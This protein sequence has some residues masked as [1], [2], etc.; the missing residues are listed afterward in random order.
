VSPAK[1]VLTPGRPNLLTQDGL[2]RLRIA[3]ND[4]LREK[5]GTPCAKIIDFIADELRKF[6]FSDTSRHI[7]GDVP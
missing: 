7:L 2:D 1:P 4:E 5:K 3:I 6:I